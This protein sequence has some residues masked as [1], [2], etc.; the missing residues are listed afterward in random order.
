LAKVSKMNY[1]QFLLKV[2]GLRIYLTFFSFYVFISYLRILG[3]KYDEISTDASLFNV[4]SG[5]F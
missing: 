4:E 3:V 2:K 1:F 5:S